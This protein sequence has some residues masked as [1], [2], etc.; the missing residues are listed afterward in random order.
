MSIMTLLLF[1]VFVMFVILGWQ[2]FSGL[3]WRCTD[4]LSAPSTLEIKYPISTNLIVKKKL[5][6][7][8]ST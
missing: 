6:E 4:P 1:I 2:L 8:G 7:I 3:F 5:T